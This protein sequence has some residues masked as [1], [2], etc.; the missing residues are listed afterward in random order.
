MIIVGL[1][2]KAVDEAKER[3]RNA[4]Q[5]SKVAFPKKRITI[6]LA[7]ADIPKASTAFDMAIAVSILFAHNKDLKHSPHTA[8]IGELGLDGSFRAVRGI[9]GMILEGKKKG[10]QTFV[11]PS[12]NLTQAKTVPAIH[13]IAVSSLQELF[14]HL[15]G[16][17]CLLPYVTGNDTYFFDVARPDLSEYVAGQQQAKRA[18]TIAAAGG[19]N[20]LM[21]GPPGTGKS[22]LAK[23]FVSLLPPPSLQEVLEIT[24]L[25]SLHENDY[26]RL[27]TERPFRSPH[28]TSSHT[29]LVG[30]GQQLLPG[31]VSL[32]HGG[33][34]FLDEMPEFSRQSLEALRQPLEDHIISI[35]RVHIRT[36]FPARFILVATANPCPCGFAGTAID[37][38]CSTTQIFRY[39]QRIS[40]PILDR[41]DLHVTVD[42]IEHDALLKTHEAKVNTPRQRAIRKAR[43]QQNSRLGNGTTTNATMDNREVAANAHLSDSAKAILQQAVKNLQLSARTYIKIIKV[44]RTI[45][46][47]EDSPT[48]MP[49]HITE[50]L[51]YRPKNKG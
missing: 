6:N 19:H 46:D 39:Q 25:Q 43:Q 3:I 17:K 42:K 50:A 9:I 51:Q 13:I 48:I 10:I 36:T 29:A 8:Y 37:C 40:G 45:A 20:I 49:A 47:L 21:T 11:I 38:V 15:T 24:H 34:L 7:P 27:F 1:A 41:I 35:A 32:S 44:S 18:L 31:E 12:G 4:F 16:Q 14:L 2:S 22:M 30:G 33:V 23:S 5:Q 26:D 28:H